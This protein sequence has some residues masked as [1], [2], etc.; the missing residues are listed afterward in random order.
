LYRYCIFL[1]YKKGHELN[2]IHERGNVETIDYR[3]NGTYVLGRVPAAIA[4][5]RLAEYRVDKEAISAAEAKKRMAKLT[6][7]R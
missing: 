2:A 3:P 4:T 7:L 5:N 1:L 6:G